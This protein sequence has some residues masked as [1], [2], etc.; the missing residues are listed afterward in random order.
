MRMEKMKAIRWIKT[1]HLELKEIPIPE[2]GDDDIL[3]E[4]KAAGICGADLHWLSG[5]FNA[6]HEVTLGH[7]FAGE[8]VEMGKNVEPLWQIGDRVVSDNTAYACGTCSACKRGQFLQCAHRIGLG[9]GTDGGFAKYCLIPGGAIRHYPSALM[10]IPDS[11]PFEEA[12][13]MEPVANMY[14]AVVQDSHIMPGQTVVVFGLG[15]I[16]LFAI[17]MCHLAGA[18]KIIAVGMSSD[19]TVRAPIAKK[20]GAN[21]VLA[22]DREEDIALKIV[23]ITGEDSVAVVYDAVGIPS[24]M[25]GVDKYIRHGGEFIRIGNVAA[26]YNHT[27]IPL[28]DKQITVVGHMGYDAVSWDNSM[29]LYK[30][31][32]LNIKDAITHVLPI[33]E[34]LTGYEMMKT[35][36]S[37]KVVLI[38]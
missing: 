11:M 34:Y 38:P 17:Q 21:I 19:M 7:E 9:G 29:E 20:M 26:I 15:P 27:L 23:E 8:I 1:K 13:C 2:C 24:I 5:S 4:V 35:Q 33:D 31:G 3:I 12:A 28:I 36:Q 32:M 22:S 30:A 10:K 16:G 37:G 6:D 14:K 18:A 25:A